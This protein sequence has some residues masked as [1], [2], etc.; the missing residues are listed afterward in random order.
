MR[1]RRDDEDPIRI[2]AQRRERRE[3]FVQPVIVR[4]RIARELDREFRRL[5]TEDGLSMNTVIRILIK[6]YVE[7]Q[8][9]VLGMI[10]Q[11]RREGARAKPPAKP[12]REMFSQGE[13]REIW[14][15][16]GKREDGDV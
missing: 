9:A 1:R 11:Y 3:A 5:L 7:H 4:G 2:E 15:E 16:I 8:P 6:G 13:L 10:E 12:S 14:E